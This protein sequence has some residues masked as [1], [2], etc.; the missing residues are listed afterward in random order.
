MGRNERAKI[1][2]SDEEI[3]EFVERSR[4]ATMATVLPNGRPHLVAMW[5]AVLDGEVWFETKAKSQKAVNLRRDP[6]VTVLIEDGHTYDT[7]RGVSID[8]TAEIADDP[9]TILR[10]GISVWERYTGP[11]T[12]EMRPYVDQMMNNR[13]AVRV[14]PGRIRSWD[15][16]KLGLPEMPVAGSTAQ[17][18][19]V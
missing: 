8:G 4:T 18:L 9:E 19:N 17:Y 11:Y 1:V 12:D 2:M 3:A 5:Y 6:T 7:L 16:R 10:V 13:I 14:V 15:H